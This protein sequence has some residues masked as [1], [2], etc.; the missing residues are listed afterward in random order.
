MRMNLSA[1]LNRRTRRADARGFTLVEL[2]I[3]MAVSLIV[4][5]AAVGFVVSLIKANSEN[6]KVTRLTQE[7][8]ALSEVMGR[9]I[10]RARYVADPVG[11]IATAGAI[12]RDAITINA[13]ADCDASPVPT[14][15]NCIVFSYDEPPDGVNP[16]VT[17]SRSIWLDGA[18]TLFLNPAPAAPPGNPC[19]GGS[20]ISTREVRITNLCFERVNSE[21]RI[22]VAGELANSPPGL[23]GVSRTF[24]QTTYVRSGQVN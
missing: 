7:L 2:M 1:M 22:V 9:E 3:A 8:R 4:A 15:A 14:T 18:N 13:V 21:V 20:R 10:R 19:A 11:L 12:N 23:A 16:A 24:R 17:V 5:L 6:L